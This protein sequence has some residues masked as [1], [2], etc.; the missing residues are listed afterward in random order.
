MAEFSIGMKFLQVVRIILLLLSVQPHHAV[1]LS[2]YTQFSLRDSHALSNQNSIECPSVWFEYNQV[3]HNCKCIDHLF[4]NCEGESVYADTNHILTYD[5]TREIISAVKMRHK[6]LEGYNLT[7]NGI[8]LPNNISELNAYM[9]GPLN[10]EDYLCSKCR[11]GYGPP[12]IFESASCV[13]VCYLCKDSWILKNL[14]LYLSLNFIPLTL[15]YLLILVFQIRLTS[16]PMTCFIMCSQLVVLAFYKECDLE[17]SKTVLSQIKF[18]DKGNTLRTGTKIILTLYAVFNLDFFSY[19]LHLFCISSMLKPIH[20]FFLGYI[21]AFYPFLLILLTWF[22]VELHG[23]NF[24]PIVC[25]WRPFHGC[26]VRLRRGW[27][28]QSDLIDVFASFFLLSYSK[29]LYLIM[30]PFDSEEI[31]NYSLMDGKESYDYV[32]SADLTTIT[33]KRSDSFMTF[34]VC[35]SVLLLLLFF[36]L[37]VFLLF[38]YPTRILRNLLSKC[39]S[40]RIL[41][42]LNTF[43]EKYHCSYKDGLD[44]TKDM[45]SFSG[46]YFLLRIIIYYAEAFSRATIKLDVYIL[47]KELFSQLL[48]SSSL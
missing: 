44:G 47:L 30:L 23:R 4:L 13:H 34:M 29:I 9:C 38:F 41:I 40:S 3:T 17:R 14:L 32:L 21:T 25:L 45:R 2:M 1:A 27:N 24:R 37:P 10:R 26:F 48:L 19:F 39:L 22:C 11:S 42:F 35:F 12:V 43:M 36:I 33:F 46:I 20:V 31:R 28:T 8:L 16:A 15:F 7:K 5:S 6:Y 18:T